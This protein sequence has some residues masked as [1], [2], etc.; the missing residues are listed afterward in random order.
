ML[1]SPAPQQTADWVIS[2]ETL[3]VLERYLYGE[4]L[5]MIYDDA[6]LF[7]SFENNYN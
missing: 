6:G 3:Q 1:C 4:V 2:F 7:L 5:N